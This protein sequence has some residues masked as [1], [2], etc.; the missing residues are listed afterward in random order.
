MS[1]KD[2]SA[3]VLTPSSSSLLNTFNLLTS[4]VLIGLGVIGGFGIF[5]FSLHHRYVDRIYRTEQTHNMT[6][7]VIRDRYI[8]ADKELQ[9]CIDTDFGRQGE[10]SELRGRLE[11]QYK[12]WHGLTE[13]QRSLNGQHQKKSGSTA[14]SASAGPTG[15]TKIGTTGT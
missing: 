13:T 9:Q 3:K 6:L 8:E 4:M 12:S 7:A 14:R 1:E 15:P 2:E 11:A 5:H 10:L